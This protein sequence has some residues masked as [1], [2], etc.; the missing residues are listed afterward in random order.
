MGGLGG[1][2]PPGASAVRSFNLL[3]RVLLLIEGKFLL[4]ITKQLTPILVQLTLPILIVA[5]FSASAEEA[6]PPAVVETWTCSYNPGQDVDDLMAA[7]DY[8]V[9]QAAKAGL[10]LG[11]AY[12][13]SLVKGDVGFD[14]LWLAPH[15]NFAAFAAAVDAES[16]A[17][18]VADVQARFDQVATCTARI[19]TIQTVFQREGADNVGDGSTIISSSAC[20]LKP[21]VEPADVEDLRGHISGVLG[22]I[23]DRAPNSVY[24]ISPTT[25]GPNTPELVLFTV[26]DSMTSYANFTGSL[27]GTEEGQSLGRH[28]RAVADCSLALWTGQQVIAPPEG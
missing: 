9:R 8:Y 26:N 1:V 27:F 16:A 19:G 6:Q 12:M 24:T 10:S 5:S 13:W 25:G 11:P 7:R 18:E 17:S 3:C 20:S 22:G 4:K 15:Q 28:F 2:G 14:L 21:G 23:G